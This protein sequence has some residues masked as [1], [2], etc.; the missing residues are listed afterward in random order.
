[1]SGECTRSCGRTQHEHCHLHQAHACSVCV[2]LVATRLDLPAHW[3]P[4][5]WLCT[6]TVR[7]LNRGAQEHSET[8]VLCKVA[9]QNSCQL[10][11]YGICTFVLPIP[12]DEEGWGLRVGVRVGWIVPPSWMQWG[13]VEVEVWYSTSVVH[14]SWTPPCSCKFPLLCYEKSC[15][16]APPWSRCL[17]RWAS[18]FLHAYMKFTSVCPA[19]RIGGCVAL[20]HCSRIEYLFL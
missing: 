16:A 15:R 11:S 7:W 13:K 19:S 5:P 20:Q 14:H 12:L 9:N 8:S 17:G 4:P 10:Q 6:A 3:N 18:M 2:M 1:M